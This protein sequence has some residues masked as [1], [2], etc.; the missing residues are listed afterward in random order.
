MDRPGCANNALSSKNKPG[1][2]AVT[3]TGV[4]VRHAPT[5]LEHIRT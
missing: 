1:V 5:H 3:V 4:A 2:F